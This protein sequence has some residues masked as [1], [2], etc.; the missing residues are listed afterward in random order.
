MNLLH[1]FFAQ[2]AARG[3]RTAIVAADGTRASYVDL[4]A[5]SARLAIAWQ[6]KGIGAGDRVLLAMPLGI[7]LYAS[8]AALWRLGAVVVFPEPAL[9]LNGLR[10][11]V[12]VTRPKAYLAGGWFRAFRV[13]W[14]ALWRIPM[15][16]PEDV[17]ADAAAGGDPLASLA[18]DHPALISFT[19][20]STG[21]PKTIVR[22]HGFLAHQNA[23]VAELLK[24]KREDE[25]DLVA[26]PVFVLANLGLGVTSV[27]PNWNLRRHHAAD[28][29]AIARHAGQHHVTR[30][31]IPPSICE[32]LARGP[33]LRLDAIFTGGG[34]VFPDLL[35]RLTARVPQ[36]DIVSVYGS[37]E[38]E[39]IAHQHVGD[40]SAED[41]RT[42]KSGGGLLAG[43]PVPE[44]QL[45]ILEHEI[46][47]TGDHVNKGYLDRADDRTTKLA[48]DD[49]IWHRT[50]DAGRIDG[51][52]RLWLLGRLDGRATSLFPF[53]VEAAARF[54][55]NVRQAALVAIDD[56]A[57][58]AIAGAPESRD[59]WQREAD[60]IGA[61]RVVAVK[62]IPLDRRHQSK[63]DYA[64]LRKLL[65]GA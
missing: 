53:A 48:L 4:M 9:G 63:I 44:I 19:S 59:L 27:L 39:P 18:A 33:A 11:A 26:F 55:P 42:M 24:P 57:I 60:R 16:T 51:T 15:I 14:P 30:A 2:A 45:K 13:A 3:A 40:I 50:G 34:P 31:L 52:G 43:A 47:V 12:D 54:W 22:S 64:S 10:H 1:P 46:V 29:G 8:L 36:A 62:S 58:L 25:V 49:T 5:Q 37:T 65:G 35:E 41:W 6:R 28:A 56:K 21:K 61:L 32:T 17:A 23:C 20:G 7:P 38:A